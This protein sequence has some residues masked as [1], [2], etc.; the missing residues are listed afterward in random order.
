MVLRFLS[1][2]SGR[3][4]GAIL[5]AIEEFL[6]HQNHALNLG[7]LPQ[8]RRAGGKKASVFFDNPPSVVRAAAARG[9]RYWSIVA[10]LPVGVICVKGE[11]TK[12]NKETQTM[13]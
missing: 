8:L 2:E 5:A 6:S 3:R 1:H 11:E 12:A 10:C 7:R 9:L 13:C 4:E